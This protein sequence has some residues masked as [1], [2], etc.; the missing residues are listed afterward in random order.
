[1]IGG[2]YSSLASVL[3]L[4]LLDEWYFR[5]VYWTYG[6]KA[7]E[8]KVLFAQVLWGLEY[9][10]QNWGLGWTVVTNDDGFV[11]LTVKAIETYELSKVRITPIHD[12]W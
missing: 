4:G 8:D 1:M 12:E 2:L 11:N 6:G 5:K 10:G 9:E 7:S 3:G